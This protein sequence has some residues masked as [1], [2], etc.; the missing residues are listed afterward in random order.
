MEIEE[1]VPIFSFSLIFKRMSSVSISPSFISLSID[2][3]EKS[4]SSKR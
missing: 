4:A 1:A 2:A 3:I